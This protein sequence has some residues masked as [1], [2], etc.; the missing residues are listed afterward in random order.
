MTAMHGSG[1]SFNYVVGTASHPG[2]VRSE[3]EDSLM[4]RPESGLWAVADGMGGHAN[5]R[6][7]SEQVA[8]GLLR[9]ALA[10]NLDA[11]CEAIADTLADINANIIEAANAADSTIGTTVVALSIS[12]HR[13][14]CLWAGDSRIYRLRGGTLQQLTRDHSH[15]E[16]LVRAGILTP[17]QA[18]DHPMANVITRAVGVTPELALDVIEDDIIG[19]DSFLLCSDGL[20]KCLNDG[21]IAAIAAA[22]PPA[23]ACQALVV[24]VLGRGAPDNV[25]IVIV[26]CE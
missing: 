13:F 15:V 9:T 24:A 6:W 18:E 26:R 10:G 20:T 3:N 2:L 12:G 1:M 14:A 17:E 8:A 19:S 4:S 21:E 22:H 16:D 5:G 11:D 7:A 25:S 23:E